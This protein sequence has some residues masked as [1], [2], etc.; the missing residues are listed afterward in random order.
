MIS[1]P[2]M[3]WTKLAIIG[4]GLVLIYLLFFSEK[5]DIQAPFNLLT[6]D[7]SIKDIRV[8]MPMRPEP[9]NDDEVP[10]QVYFD[11][12]ADITDLQKLKAIN[13]ILERIKEVNNYRQFNPA[14]RQVTTFTPDNS[15]L[16]Y[17]N[18]YILDKLSFYSGGQYKFIVDTMDSASGSQTEDQYML[19]YNLNGRVG[20][21]GFA[22]KIIVII[23]K[24]DINNNSMD[25]SFNE[26]R[27]DNPEVFITPHTPFNNNASILY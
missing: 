3:N 8:P 19:S 13:N 26:I 15:K 20:S 25:I 9:V 16:T 5:F 24:P 23:S 21:L 6:S 11:K 2:N 4:L 22:I 1:L 18:N 17:I 27:V 12:R 7:A 10:N 14:L